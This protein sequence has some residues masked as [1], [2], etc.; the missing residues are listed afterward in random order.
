MSEH[1]KRP[2]FWASMVLGGATAHL[3]LWDAKWGA[4]CGLFTL[5]VAF[6]MP[7]YTD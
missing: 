5:F 2:S 1:C 7:R 6:A 3:L 4:V